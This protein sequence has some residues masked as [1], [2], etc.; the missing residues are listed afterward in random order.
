MRIGVL[1]CFSG[2]AGDMWVAALLDAGVP[3]A[4]LQAAVDSLG[5]PGV[6]IRV[7][8]TTRATLAAT[9]FVV[10]LAGDRPHVHRHLSD[11]E[12][13]LERAKVPDAVRQAARGVFKS[14]A[15]AEADAH[16]MSVKAVHF[17]EVGA[18]DALVD[19]VCACLGTSLLGLDKL[20]CGPVVVGSG[21]V[22][23]AHG[24]MPVPAPGTL[25]VLQAHGIP[26]TA[27]GLTNER[28]TPTGV[29]L[30]AQLVDSFEAPPLMRPVGNGLGAGT[31]DDPNHPNVL[32][33]TLGEV[34]ATVA[35]FGTPPALLTEMSCNLDTATGETIGWL[36][37]RAM[38]LGALDAW[39]EPLLMKKGRPGHKLCAL[40]ADDVRDD[41][42]GLFLE[43][44]STLGVR[45]HQ[46]SRTVLKRWEEVRT[47]ALGPV[48]FKCWQ[49]PS[50]RIHARPEDAELARL[51]VEHR[52]DRSTV[53]AQLE[54]RA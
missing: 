24:T 10:D 54:Q 18:E 17:H 40:V 9:R 45:M 5:L 6:S 41:V 4:P 43:D 11:V 21:T 30:V 46:V 44:S 20:Y 39:A 7:E 3:L 42:A 53:L 32:R 15:E 14:I 29:A 37:E 47:T 22:E 33:L 36:I 50:G 8:K 13:I 49:T 1:D 34:A 2:V 25:G 23:C 35:S 51:S 52:I 12:A 16:G 19:V 26:S 48:Q 31:R 38:A 27:G 28:A